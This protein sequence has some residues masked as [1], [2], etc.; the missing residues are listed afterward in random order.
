MHTLKHKDDQSPATTID[1]NSS[2]HPQHKNVGA[3][4]SSE[5]NRV[6]GGQVDTQVTDSVTQI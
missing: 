3:T 2:G 6:T 5:L 4:T 1:K